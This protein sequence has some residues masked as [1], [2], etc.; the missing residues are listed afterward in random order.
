MEELLV[1][2][3]RWIRPDF[4]FIVP[5]LIGVGIII[6]YR[7]PQNNKLIPLFLLFVAVPIATIWGFI[8]SEYTG[9]AKIFDAFV[10]AGLAQGFIATAQ[11]VM[12]YS[13]V[14]GVKRRWKEVKKGVENDI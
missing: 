5:I 11:A 12:I 7:T 8:T 6:K 4:A 13:T 14:H 2:F 9:G 1:D 3:D 10:I